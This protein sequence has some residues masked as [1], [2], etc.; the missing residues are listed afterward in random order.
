MTVDQ[1]ADK[2][3]RKAVAL[4]GFTAEASVAAPTGRY[5]A[6]TRYVLPG[7]AAISPAANWGS[8][9]QEHCRDGVR[10]YSAIL[11]NIPWGASWER[12]CWTTLGSPAGI[13]ARPPDR[14]VNTGFNMWGQWDVPDRSCGGWGTPSIVCVD[15]PASPD[16]RCQICT[17]NNGDGTASTWHTC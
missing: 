8:F 16:P 10:Q 3:E 6:R 9:R 14:C 13:P 2:G 15:D 12:A 7:R 11:W 17:R 4:P 5:H 1:R